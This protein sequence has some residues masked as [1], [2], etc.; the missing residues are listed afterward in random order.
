MPSQESVALVELIKSQGGLGALSVEAV[1]ARTAPAEG[2]PPLVE[3]TVT[4]ATVSGGVPGEFINAPGAEEHRIVL[5]FHG[6]GYVMGNSPGHRQFCS[7][8]SAATGAR[9]LS[10]DYRLAPEN[11]YP[12][13]ATDGVF[14][15]QALVESGFAPGNIAIAGDS[16]GGGIAFSVLHQIKDRG[17]PMPSCAIGISPWT[18]LTNS[19]ASMM[20]R[21]DVDPLL[22]G[23]ALQWFANQYVTRD[24]AKEAFASPLLGDI[25]GFPPLLI[26]CGTFEVLYD[27]SARMAEAAAKA[28]VSCTFEP[29]EG[30]IHVFP[31]IAPHLPESAEAV[32]R[33]GAFVKSHALGTT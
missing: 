20:A 24:Q 6:G 28:G 25:T 31:V 16:A 13:A 33:M 4:A 23:M 17:L 2:A 18:D 15:Y 12:A 30:Q 3:G 27:D 21:A 8:L 19:G 29:Y 9:V 10:V 26:Q 22:T 1:R 11:P 14:A 32:A 7:R 5:Y